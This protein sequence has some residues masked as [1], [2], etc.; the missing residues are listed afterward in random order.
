[1]AGNKIGGIKARAK[2]LA[3]DPDFYKKIGQRGGQNGNTGGFKY[4]A[5]HDP[6]AHRKASSKG[7]SKSRKPKN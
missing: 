1:M 7:G 5:E 6:D 3:R 4:L 2:I